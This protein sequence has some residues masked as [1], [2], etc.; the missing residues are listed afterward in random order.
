MGEILGPL[1][2]KDLKKCAEAGRINADT[3]IRK[4]ENGQ[5]V[6]ANRVKG[7]INT[8]KQEIQPD[9]AVSKRKEEI[10]EENDAI[11]ALGLDP[12]SDSIANNPSVTASWSNDSSS[13]STD[14]ILSIHPLKGF[15]TCMPLSDTTEDFFLGPSVRRLCHRNP[16][17]ESSRL[18][19]LTIEISIP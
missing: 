13:V 16:I 6:T 2:A 1:N 8:E 12:P 11:R 14:S 10:K 4:G 17:A 3:W 5:W 15:A 7:L 18:N 19:G 9:A